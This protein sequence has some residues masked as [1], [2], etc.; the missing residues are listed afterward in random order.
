[1]CRRVE[2]P[3]Y[4]RPQVRESRHNRY[5]LVESRSETVMQHIGVGNRTGIRGTHRAITPRLRRRPTAGRQ[6]RALPASR[7]RTPLWRVR[8]QGGCALRVQRA[9]P[10]RYEE[11]GRHAPGLCDLR[12]VDRSADNR[13]RVLIC[14]GATPGYPTFSSLLLVSSCLPITLLPPAGPQSRKP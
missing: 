5:R 6:P 13:R 10:Q 12:A 1:M 2:G 3:R 14:G 4:Q 7:P 11:V 8:R 9:T